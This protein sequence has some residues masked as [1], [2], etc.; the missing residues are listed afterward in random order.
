ERLQPQ[1]LR[2]EQRTQLYLTGRVS[3]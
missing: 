3:S 2:T 1:N